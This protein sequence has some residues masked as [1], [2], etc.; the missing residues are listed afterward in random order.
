MTDPAVITATGTLDGHELT[1]RVVGERVEG[2]AAAAAILRELVAQG[3]RVG[4]GPWSGPA[5]LTGDPL[6]V[7]ATLRA[8]F[9]PGDV[10]VEGVHV[11]EGGIPEHSV[12]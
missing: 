11:P 1:V 2:D 8:I 5:T 3:V 4:I 9:D 12:A 10:R 6:A 7:M